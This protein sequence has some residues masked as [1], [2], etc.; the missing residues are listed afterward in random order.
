MKIVKYFY[1][2][3]FKKSINK[4]SAVDQ[5]SVMER[6]NLFLSDP[7]HPSLKTHKLKGQLKNYWAFSLNYHFRI[8]F[9]FI[10]DTT[11][12]FIN[13]GTHEIYN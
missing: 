13:I 9:R 4:F 6:I 2:K 3:E 8:I 11:V 7:H 1:T 5:Q 10:S 12:E